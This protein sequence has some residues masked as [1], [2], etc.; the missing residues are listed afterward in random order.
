MKGGLQL[1]QLSLSVG[2]KPGTA[3]PALN[4]LSSQGSSTSNNEGCLGC[5]DY[6]LFTHAFFKRRQRFTKLMYHTN[7]DDAQTDQSLVWQYFPQIN[8]SGKQNQ[9]QTL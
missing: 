2:L 4:L 9:S 5:S 3:R 7:C 1:N 8:V 6:F